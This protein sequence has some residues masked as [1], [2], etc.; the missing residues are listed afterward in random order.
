MKKI[1][2]NREHNLNYTKNKIVNNQPCKR[3]NHET[4]TKI[5]STNTI[6]DKLKKTSGQDRGHPVSSVISEYTKRVQMEPF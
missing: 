5:T 6:T 4:P 1:T 2:Q 3:F